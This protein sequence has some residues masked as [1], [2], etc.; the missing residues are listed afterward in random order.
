MAEPQIQFV[1]EDGTGLANANAFI[2]LEYALQ[3]WVNTGRGSFDLVEAQ[4]PEAAKQKA[5][6]IRASRWL[7]DSFQWAGYLK[8]YRSNTN[9]RQ[10]LD[11]PRFYA[12]YE[13]GD[14]VIS[15]WSYWAYALVD[16][17]SVPREIQEATAEAAW[18][19]YQNP[20]GLTPVFVAA[21]RE[22]SIGGAGV[23][24]IKYKVDDVG[25]FN[26]RPVLHV[27]LDLVS[28]LLADAGRSSR[29]GETARG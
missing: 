20:H 21:E 9:Q 23:P 29:F 17:D 13:D 3:H 19:E 15:D 22:M 27:V 16:S 1:V 28:N 12:A 14:F 2:S 10:G 6:I 4:N 5:A 18:Y 24:T 26:S 11:W 7:S 8:V 25:A